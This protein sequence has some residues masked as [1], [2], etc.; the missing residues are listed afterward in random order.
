MSFGRRQTPSAALRLAG[1]K[2]MTRIV[3]LVGWR[4]VRLH[5]L[6][7]VLRRAIARHHFA[8][9]SG[10]GFGGWYIC[11]TLIVVSATRYGR[12]CF[13]AFGCEAFVGDVWGL[14]IFASTSCRL[15][16]GS[17]SGCFRISLLSLF[18]PP[19]VA[20]YPPLYSC[21]SHAVRPLSLLPAP[22]LLLWP[23]PPPELPGRRFTRS[24]WG[25][26]GRVRVILIA[27]LQFVSN[28]CVA[29][30]AICPKQPERGAERR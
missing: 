17:Y 20:T 24:G 23:D 16:V 21:L 8:H 28:G 30:D 10:Y 2:T 18:S 29:R 22:S 5:L 25:G 1:A 19:R 7:G 27:P 6:L 13:I 4:P 12:G 26:R 11:T 15:S 14:A 3:V 9:R